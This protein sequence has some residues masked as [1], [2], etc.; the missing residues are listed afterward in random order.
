MPKDDISQCLAA[1]HERLTIPLI[2]KRA[3]GEILHKRKK[4]LTT[5]IYE[6]T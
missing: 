4:E 6:E 5:N 1:L 2:D 3:M